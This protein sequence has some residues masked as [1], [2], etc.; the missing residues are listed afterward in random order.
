MS[1]QTALQFDSVQLAFEDGLTPADLWAAAVFI[2]FSH[3]V[4]VIIEL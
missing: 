4:K 2:F 1:D 3:G